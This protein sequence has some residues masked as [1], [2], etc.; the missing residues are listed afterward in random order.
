M[1]CDVGCPWDSRTLRWAGMNNQFEVVKFAFEQGCPTNVSVI[2]M[3]AAAGH[4]EL[5]KWM[6]M[7]DFPQNHRV[8]NWACEGV[9][10]EIVQY[11]IQHPRTCPKERCQRRWTIPHL[12]QPWNSKILPGRTLFFI[13]PQAF[14]FAALS[15]NLELIKVLRASGGFWNEHMVTQLVAYMPRLLS[16]DYKKLV[17]GYDYMY[18][19]NWDDRETAHYGYLNC[20]RYAY[21]NGVYRTALRRPICSVLFD[22]CCGINCFNCRKYIMFEPIIKPLLDPYV[23]DELVSM[24]WECGSVVYWYNMGNLHSQGSGFNLCHCHQPRVFKKLNFFFF[25]LLFCV[26]E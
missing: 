18:S 12:M 8:L 11:F 26:V 7:H 5:V 2:A 19:K 10:M 22:G 21:D 23:P 17:E 15:G 6:H 3:T 14:A 13:Q 25:F 1:F 16:K 20:L 9:N 4:L 24:E